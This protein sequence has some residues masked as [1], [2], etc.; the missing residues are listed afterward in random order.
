[1]IC[2][3]DGYKFYRTY[4][5]GSKKKE[6]EAF[7]KVQGTKDDN[8]EC[9]WMEYS[10]L[11]QIHFEDILHV[12]QSWKIMTFRLSFI[13]L[14]LSIVFFNSVLAFSAIMAFSIILMVLHF[15]LKQRQIRNMGYFQLCISIAVKESFKNFNFT[16]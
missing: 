1:M 8:S 15:K 14:I 10:V 5:G 6:L 11:L 2:K 3:F 7:L 9:D 16:K 13:L 12:I 4:I